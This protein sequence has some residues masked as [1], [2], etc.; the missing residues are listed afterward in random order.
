MN[1]RGANALITGGGHRL[2]RA[3]ALRLAAAGA[4]L[5]LNYHHSASAA[6]RTRDEVA[7]CGVRCIT[8]GAD[9]A[10]V[11][12][13]AAMA[14]RI[15]AE[16]GRLDLWVANAG[17]FRRTPFATAKAGDWNEM[18]GANFLTFARPAALIGARLGERGGCIVA[19][20]DVAAVRPWADHLPYSIAKSCLLALLRRLAVDLAPAV[21]VNAIAPGPVLFPPDLPP[22]QRQRE[23]DHT[24]LRR[25]GSAADVARAVIDLAENDYVTGVLYP[26]DAGRLLR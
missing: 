1:L 5:A 21:R 17:T 6:A 25:Q 7:A 24:L 16:L 19:I 22:D 13:V 18:W 9:A 26:V 14:A 10:D 4:N 15:D 11:S 3:I 20:A 23:I 12:A 2:G 8:L